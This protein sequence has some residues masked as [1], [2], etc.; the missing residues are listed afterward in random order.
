[1]ERHAV[2][3]IIAW[4]IIMFPIMTSPLQAFLADCQAMAAAFAVATVPVLIA[5]CLLQ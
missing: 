1:M 4:H 3:T 2:I 5:Y